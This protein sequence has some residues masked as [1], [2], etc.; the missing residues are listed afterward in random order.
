MATLAYDTT[1]ALIPRVVGRETTRP[2]VSISSQAR[3]VG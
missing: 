1:H 3:I 2:H